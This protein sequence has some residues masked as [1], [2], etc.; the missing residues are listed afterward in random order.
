MG[1]I[2]F[3]GMG[4][5][6]DWDMLI[7][8]QIQ[9]RSAHIIEPIERWKSSWEEKLT[10]FD[11]LSGRL[12]NLQSAAEAM[13]TPTKL[14]SYIAQSSNE[15]VVDATA[16]GT[17]SP[18]HYSMEIDRLATAAVQIHSGVHG[19]DTVINNSGSTQQFV[20]TYG[21]ESVTL[22]VPHGTTLSELVTLVNTHSANPGVTASILDDGSSS[23]T[24]HHLVLRGRDTGAPH[25][26]TVGEGTTL[27]GEWSAL[28]ADA[29]AGSSSLAVDD[30]SSLRQYQAILVNDDGGPAEYHI[31]DSIS[32]ET[33]SL[34]GTLS[35]SFTV[36]QNAYATARGL[37]SGLAEA[38]SAGTNE[39]A[40]DDASAFYVGA[41]V[42]V[43][44]GNGHEE[45]TIAAIDTTTNTLTFESN[46][47]NDYAADAY[48]TQIEGGRR[49]TF[50]DSDFAEQ[51]A[52][53]NARFRVDGFP[54]EGWIERER[55]VVNDVVPGLTLSL[56]G[57][58]G[59]SPVSVSVTE[60]HE[61]VKE[62]IHAFVNA[63]N[64][65]KTFLNKQT[66]YDP[67]S[68]EA[69][70]L[71]GNYAADLVNQQLRNIIIH[72]VPGFEDGTDA[73]AHLGQIGIET[74]G[75]TSDEAALGT[76]RLDEQ[77]LDE[78]LARNFDGV[79][80]LLSASFQGESSS[81]HLT[82]YQSRPD[83]TVPG[84][85]EVEADF[86]ESGSLVGGRMRLASESEFRDATVSGSYLV[87][88]T[89]S[90]EEGLWVGASWDGVSATQAATIRLKHGIGGQMA[91]SVSDILDPTEG[92]L[93]NIDSSYRDIVAQID[94]RIER[95]QARLESLRERL[96]RKYARLEQMLVQMQ[97]QQEWTQSMI[98]TMSWQS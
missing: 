51:Q 83:R 2:N 58:T 70:L 40:V 98:Q 78:A 80:D 19:A 18:G 53:R 14:R 37:G 13:D 29:G 82:F 45:L 32:G 22:Y 33:L 57:T 5:G 54:A 61:A 90:P 79:I 62:K 81:G 1:S 48:V 67:A 24:S 47:L 42:L 89:G 30:A 64:E 46:V 39:L 65:V 56:T 73:F 31:I 97:G 91:N 4:S 16:T 50:A 7:E 34:Q 72:Q 38:A 25:T 28:T 6:I 69:G 85:Y 21:Q 23:G 71:L 15:S 10:A 26:I 49:F 96:T 11:Q 55:N 9:A 76:L 35:R 20:Y 41:T 77:T 43:A 17:A 87:G 84:T 36:D 93:R 92:I 66:D 94:D 59:G 86:D 3:S 75:R 52:A 44:D 8:H 95:E 74:V 88:A 12:Q 63:Y 68:E 60:D 27:S